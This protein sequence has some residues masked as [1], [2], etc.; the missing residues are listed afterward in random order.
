MFDS[1]S[2]TDMALFNGIM[3]AILANNRHNPDFIKELTEGFAELQEH[4]KEWTP[5]RASV[6]CG[7]NEESVP[8]CRFG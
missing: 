1:T 5:A 6:I 4:L 7:S 3:H 8:R 2:V